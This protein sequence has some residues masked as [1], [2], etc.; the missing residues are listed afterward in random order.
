[1]DAFTRA[2]AAAQF[3]LSQTPLRPTIGLV[4]GSGLGGFA[5]ELC[6]ATRIPYT[7]IPSFPRSIA[8]PVPSHDVNINGTFNVFRAAMEAKAGRV[9][10]AAFAGKQAEAALTGLLGQQTAEFTWE[11]E[12]LLSDMPHIDRDL[13]VVARELDH[14]AKSASA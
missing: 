14:G 13:E 5:D 7:E 11:P 12:S 1:M 4:L 2:E 10:Y 3:L 9:V 8:D 6:Q